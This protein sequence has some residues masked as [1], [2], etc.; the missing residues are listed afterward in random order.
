M[1]N[2]DWLDKIH[3]RISKLLAMARD[4][5]SPEEAAIAMERARK[6]M[7]KHQISEAAVEG[8]RKSLADQ[9]FEDRLHGKEYKYAPKWRGILALAVAQ[10]NDCQNYTAAGRLLFRGFAEDVEMSC[11]MFDRLADQ[12]EQWCK[13]HMKAI[14]H[15]SHYIAS[16]GNPYKYGM[17]VRLV[18]KL[19][20]LRNDRD[21]IVDNQG[22]SLVVV[23]TEMVAKHFQSEQK[24]KKVK[25]RITNR[26]AEYAFA[27]GY[28]DGEHVSVRDQVSE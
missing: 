7:D 28:A 1:N 3:D 15:G 2:A 5:S 23:K 27:K 6:L 14:G 21:G 4:Q 9:K 18:A 17:A 24:I 19:N 20:E 11:Q 10:F 25:P 22:Q 26:D 13:L 16:I 8:F 12:I